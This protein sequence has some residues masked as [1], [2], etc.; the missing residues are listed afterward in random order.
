M[1]GTQATLAAAP[2]QGVGGREG[3][4]RAWT[5][6]ASSRPLLRSAPPPESETRNP[7]ACGVRFLGSTL[8]GAIQPRASVAG[9]HVD[10]L[11][12]LPSRERAPASADWTGS[13]WGS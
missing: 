8:R 1:D 4:E 9:I 11:P 7:F 5:L 3:V 6:P 12:P 13:V 10:R 2:S